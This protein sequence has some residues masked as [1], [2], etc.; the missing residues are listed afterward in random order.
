MLHHRSMSVAAAASSSLSSTP[1]P[2]TQ[3][4]G[5]GKDGTE[6][7]TND[8][9]MPLPTQARAVI[10]H[11]TQLTQ[12]VLRMTAELEFLVLSNSSEFVDTTRVYTRELVRLFALVGLPLMQLLHRILPILMS[13]LESRDHLVQIY[14]LHALGALIQ[15]LH[16]LVPTAFTSQCFLSYVLPSYL[17][18]LLLPSSHW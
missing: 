7:S 12:L 17:T 2:P 1:S 5:A 13:L 18:L 14:S 4:T 9:V 16:R 11:H 3:Y 10:E 15:V 6:S 8:D